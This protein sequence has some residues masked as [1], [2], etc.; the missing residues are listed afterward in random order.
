MAEGEISLDDWTFFLRGGVVLDRTEQ[1]PKPN[2]SWISAQAWDH[3][4]ELEKALPE[5]FTGLTTSITHSPKEWHR[6]YMA[7]KPEITPLPAEWE[8]K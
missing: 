7:L 2:A 5:V 4:T 8:T 6:W 3:V 1:P